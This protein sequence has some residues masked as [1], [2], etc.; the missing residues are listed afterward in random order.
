M[1]LPVEYRDAYP[2]LLAPHPN[3]TGQDGQAFLHLVLTK[4]KHWAYEEEWRAIMHVAKGGAATQ[5]VTLSYRPTALAG[6]IFGMK[7]PEDHRQLIRTVL[8]GHEHV[9]YY[10]AV[11]N[12][13]T[14]S[15]DIRELGNPNE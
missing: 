3:T 6:I 5:V 12:D 9:T 13:E 8:G 11:K 15:L 7:M 4:S 10:M 14:Y 1:C 2:D